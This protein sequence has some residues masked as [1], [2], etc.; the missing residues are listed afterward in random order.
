[1]KYLLIVS[2]LLFSGISCSNP[3]KAEESDRKNL[4]QAQFFLEQGFPGRALQ[5]AKRIKETSPRYEEAQEL[6]FRIEGDSVEPD[7]SGY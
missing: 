1:M 6:I 4:Y 2:F 3:G 7:F 5:H